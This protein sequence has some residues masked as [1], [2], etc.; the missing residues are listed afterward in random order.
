MY[1]STNYTDYFLQSLG[2][3]S[4]IYLSFVIPAFLIFWIFFS[5]RFWPI[6]IQQVQKSKRQNFIQD[7]LFSLSTVFIFGAID[8]II[9]FLE[10]KGIT[11]VYSDINQFGWVWFIV[12]ILI[13]F[14]LHDTYFY[15]T[16]RLMH[17]P[18]IFRL[19]HRTHHNSTDPSPWTSY[20][21]HPIEAIIEYGISFIIVFIMP[22][23]FWALIIWQVLQMMF[24]VIGHLGFEIYPKWWLKNPIL[25][26]KNPSTHHN[27]HHQKFN[28]N[29]GLYFAW[30]DKWMGTEFKDYE[31]KFNEIFSKKT[32]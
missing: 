11:Q 19:V 9:Y 1:E 13:M 4:F 30:W 8:V 15:W 32:T 25:K 24:N 29:Y 26:W 28:G 18:K 17:H 2:L 27:M 22:V 10:N 16:H 6:R 20:A 23:N 12:S 3:E 5:K 31:K 21:F 7:G 14:I